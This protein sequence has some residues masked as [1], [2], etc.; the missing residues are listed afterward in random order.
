MIKQ[1]YYDTRE[2][3]EF[4][5]ISVHTLRNKLSKCETNLPPSFRVGRKRLFPC[6]DFN[7]WL[8]R[9]RLEG[10]PKNR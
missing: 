3:S 4:L 5:H 9:Q 10:K 6:H 8:N 1:R 2:V 7:E